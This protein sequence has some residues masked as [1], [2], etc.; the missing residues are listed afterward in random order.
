MDIFR[1][2]KTTFEPV[3]SLTNENRDDYTEPH[4]SARLSHFTDTAVTCQ[5]PED[6]VI[7]IDVSISMND[8]D[9]PPTRLCGGIEAAVEYVH[10]RS[11]RHPYDRIAVASFSNQG[12]VVLGLTDISRKQRIISAIESL[13]IESGTDIKAGLEQALCIFNNDRQSG[14]SRRVI[15]L[16]DGHGGRPL[17]TAQRLKTSYNTLIDVAG[18]GGTSEDVN[19]KLLKKVATT[20]PDGFNHYYFIKDSK[21]LKDHYRRLACG[22]IRSGG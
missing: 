16:T 10:A 6:T 8:D 4:A 13:T 17:S 5:D 3:N 21:G 19:E 7:I 14:R 18:I 22:L 2:L 20:D 1:L 11:Q 15:L 9:Y 12:R